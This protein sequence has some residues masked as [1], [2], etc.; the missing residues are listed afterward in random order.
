MRTSRALHPLV[1]VSFLAAFFAC[2]K[3][4]ASEVNAATDTAKSF[5]ELEKRYADSDPKSRDTE[6]MPLYR[7]FAEQHAGTD[8]AL[9]ASLWLLRNTWSEREA[10][11]MNTSAEKIVRSLL[12][13]YSDSARLGEVLEYDWTLAAPFQKEVCE[14]MRASKHEAVRAAGTLKLAKRKLRSKEVEEKRL[15]EQL[16]REIEAQYAQLKYKYT[17][18]GA[19]AKAQL[20]PHPR[21]ALKIGATAPDIQGFDADGKP[22]KLADYRGKVVVLDFWGGW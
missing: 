7:A 20:N 14:L 9:S 19:M 16:L 15:G 5:A 11:T 10:G 22:F 4:S 8:E 3:L 12:A 1:C 2:C 21:D 13:K 17:T 6:F 18:Y